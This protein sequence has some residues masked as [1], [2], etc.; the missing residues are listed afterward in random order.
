MNTDDEVLE[1]ITKHISCKLPSIHDD[2]DLHHLVNRYQYHRC[3]NYCLRRT[4]T[5]KHRCT[6]SF[7]RDVRSKPVLH[8][9]LASIVSRQSQSYRRRLYELERK[10]SEQRINDYNHI[11]LWLWRGN[12][13]LQFIGEE[14][15]TLVDYI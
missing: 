13:D 9:V 12:I 10:S 11:L 7:P 3:N 1:F 5:G 6:F 4:K 15:E 2:S 14:S 8:S